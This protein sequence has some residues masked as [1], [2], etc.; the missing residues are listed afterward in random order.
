MDLTTFCDR[1]DEELSTGEYAD[2]DASA[3]GLQVGPDSGTVEHAA[4]AVDAATATIDRAAEAGADVLV[5]HHGVSWG[6]FDRVTGTHYRRV[7]P[8]VENDLALYA[9]HLPLDGHQRLGNAAG[10]ADLLDLT[11]REPFGELGPVSVGQ[12]GRAS[13]PFDR[14]ALA[15][16]LSERLA[17]G[18]GE[19]RT[20]DFGPDAV[21]DVAIVTGSGTDWLDEAVAVG[22]DALVTGEGKQQVYHEAREA[23]INVYLAGH[24]AT[25][26]FGVRALADLAADWGLSTTYLDH[27]TGI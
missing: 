11:D 21:A 12:R 20:L 19:V 8:L 4:F 25:E 27:P 5:V 26:T 17:T 23:G 15:A 6:G 9:A 10:V 18:D 1:L 13:D 24:Y 14:E 3:N 16:R 2:V 7:A 22:A